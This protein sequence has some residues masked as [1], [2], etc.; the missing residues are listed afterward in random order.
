MTA[1]STVSSV[2]VAG[3]AS[4]EPRLSS[5]SRARSASCQ[6]GA[7]PP[8]VAQTTSGRP[9]ARRRACRNRRWRSAGPGLPRIEALAGLIYA[10]LALQG[11]ERHVDPALSA[12]TEDLA[13]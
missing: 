10:G 12:L 13:R 2:A 8:G 3:P 6:S 4:A 7:A 11:M 1:I 9:S 5:V